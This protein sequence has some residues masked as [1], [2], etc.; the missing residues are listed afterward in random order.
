ML[1][2][3]GKIEKRSCLYKTAMQE[4]SV[5]ASRNGS[6]KWAYLKEQSFASNYFI[7]LNVLY[8]FKNLLER[9]DL[10]Y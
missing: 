7:L 5:K 2:E 8:Q 10:M 4:A 1:A 3:N 9:V 6:T